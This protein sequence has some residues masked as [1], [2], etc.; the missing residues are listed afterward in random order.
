MTLR[1][2]LERAYQVFFTSGHYDFSIIHLTNKAAKHIKI[3]EVM[4]VN[5]IICENEILKWLNMVKHQSIYGPRGRERRC[6][7]VQPNRENKTLISRHLHHK[8]IIH[9]ILYLFSFVE[10]PRK[11]IIAEL[12]IRK[13]GSSSGLIILLLLLA[14]MKIR[15]ESSAIINLRGV[16]T[17]LNKYIVFTMQTY[18]KLTRYLILKSIL[19]YKN[20]VPNLFC[21]MRSCKQLPDYYRN[22]RILSV[23]M[24]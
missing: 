9:G 18:K 16:S 11:F 15:A 6:H 19:V 1:I 4:K 2:R 10:T 5:I 24:E 23:P 17:K 14:L 12:S 7:V 20:Q 8:L 3:A 13:L 22:S 21:K